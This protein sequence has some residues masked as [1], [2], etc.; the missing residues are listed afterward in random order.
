[1]QRIGLL[2]L[3]LLPMSPLAR[4]Q[5][6]T[7]ATTPPAASATVQTITLGNSAVALTGPW[8]FQPGDSP[9][10]NGSPLRAQPQFNDSRWATMDLTPKAGDVDL[11]LGTSNYVPGWTSKGYPNL[12]GYAWY[13]LRLRVK[14]A[15]QAVWLQMPLD[16]DDAYQVYA[17]G[18][19]L[20]HFGGFS[21]QH[22]TLYYAK[23][24]SF[25]LPAPGPDGEIDLAVRFYMSPATQFDNPDVGGM[26]GPPLLGL[27][28][29]VQLLQASE[30]DALLHSQFSVLLRLFLFLLIMPLAL[31]AWRYNPQERAWLWL[32][33]AL[34]WAVFINGMGLLSALTSAVSIADYTW[35]YIS[36]LPLWLIFWWHWFG[37]RDRRWIPRAAWLLA[38]VITSL[39]FCAHSPDLGFTF[40]PLTA[41]HWFNAAANWVTAPYE[42]LLIVILVEGYR[43]D[44]TE[45]LLASFPILL[46]LYSSFNIYLLTAF[47]I[48]TEFFPFGLGVSLPN[49]TN[50]LMVVVVAILSLRRFVRTQVHDSLVH[51]AARK[52]LEQAQQLQQRVLVP[53]IPDSSIFAVETEY[54][55]ALTVGGDFFQTL[56]Q[57]GGGLILVIG[58]VS[59]KGISAA[60]LV[61]VLVGAIR[62]H[63]EY[64]SD[65]ASML[66]M[67]NRRMIGRAGGH[68]AT[69]L[70]AE[71]SPSGL[72]RIANAGH[73]P[74]YRNGHELD[75]EGSLPLGIAE[76][77]VY[78]VQTFQL[79]P[80]DR[81]TF[82]TD[83]VIEAT[84]PARELFGFDRTRTISHH[85]AS[86]I[87]DQVVTFGQE[88]DI[89]VL[90]VA[91][92]PA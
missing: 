65:P 2:L 50:M 47:H 41:L 72:M 22:V 74:P 58:D 64:A 36:I 52:D 76:D 89:T 46:Y 27:A 35:C 21:K 71:I 32:F 48:P 30:Q 9:I 31:W 29:I 28:S 34:A 83:G 18:R 63:A 84:N 40:V 17:N 85:P 25:A 82:I 80:G 60:M 19:Y 3:T 13:R 43:R 51:E 54:R 86:A 88:D 42:L 92:S 56:T 57:P 10:V 62:S 23:P 49:V 55:P 59:G 8:K 26:H 20:G 81:L 67:L 87:A 16:F 73:I 12:S 69:C 14:D 53:D 61:A 70:A 6:S 15:S 5:S 79:A 68:F 37:L 75:L 7:A 38:A 66:A 1:M 44:R 78:P 39:L 77:V 4:A 91:F 45:A 90:G 24:V 33:L 11:E